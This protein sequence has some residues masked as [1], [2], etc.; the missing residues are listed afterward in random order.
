MIRVLRV[1][2]YT[3]PDVQSYW[4]DRA[5]WTMHSPT[6]RTNHKWRMSSAVVSET[7][8]DDDEAKFWEQFERTPIRDL[9][10][11]EQMERLANE[12]D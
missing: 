8:I 3:Y 9:I 4:D 10:S 1:I 5:R 2:E 11:D 7:L 6:N 12:D